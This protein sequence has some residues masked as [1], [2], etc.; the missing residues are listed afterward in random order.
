MTFSDLGLNKTLVDKCESLDFS[1]PTPI[2]KQAI[3]V[4]LK[5]ADLIG[6]AETGTGKTAAFLLPT[7]QKLILNEQTRRTGF[8]NCPDAR[9]GFADRRGIQ[10]ICDEKISLCQFDRRRKYESADQ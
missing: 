2:Q 8:N 7:I 1:E 6:C 9:T 5:G 10:T 4:I 3:P